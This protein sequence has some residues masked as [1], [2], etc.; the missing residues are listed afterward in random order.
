MQ[1]LELQTSGRKL[2]VNCKGRLLDFNLPVAMGILNITPDSFFEGSRK[3]TGNE[4][5]NTAN[6]LLNQG[7]AILDIGGYSSRPGADFVSEEEELNRVIPAI[8]QII[9]H[10]PDVIIS[11]DTFRSSVAKAA[12]EAGACIV[13]DIS[14][15]EDDPNMMA[16]VGKLGVPYIMMHK[17]GNPQT[18]Q[19]FAQY[20]NVTQELLTYFIEKIQAAKQQG[21]RDIIIDPG[22]GFAKTLEHNYTL[23]RTLKEFHILGYPLLVGVSR[24]KMIQLVTHTQANEALNGTTAANTIALMNGA[25]I[26]RVHDVKEAVECINI[27]K[28][29]YECI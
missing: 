6:N 17:R 27:V 16:T 18:M 13:N 9:Q 19:Q 12:V 3:Q 25:D 10:F 23:L 5:I 4:L 22:F 15:G 29:T 20:E 2:T 28:A 21:I 24:K 11:I 26:L 1:Q 8:E 7:A 14:S